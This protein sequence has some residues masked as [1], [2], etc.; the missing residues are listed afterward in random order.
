MQKSMYLVYKVYIANY[1]RFIHKS[2]PNEDLEKVYALMG[3]STSSETQ[4][5]I[6]FSILVEM[7]II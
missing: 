3:L 1:S 4:V 2:I 6:A 5:E 7:L